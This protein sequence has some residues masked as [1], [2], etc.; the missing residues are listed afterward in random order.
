VKLKYNCRASIAANRL[1]GAGDKL[2]VVT[3][4]WKGLTIIWPNTFSYHFYFIAKQT[5]TVAFVKF[6]ELPGRHFSKIGTLEFL[7]KPQLDQTI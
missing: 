3:N 7:H 2:V 4:N 6:L 5:P 1:L